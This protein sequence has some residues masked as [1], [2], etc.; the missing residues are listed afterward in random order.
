VIRLAFRFGRRRRQADV[1]QCGAVKAVKGQLR[2][3]TR[4]PD[5]G[6]PAPP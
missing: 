2:A 4:Y 3:A 5:L 1:S 6:Q